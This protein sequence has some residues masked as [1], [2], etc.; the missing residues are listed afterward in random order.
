MGQSSTF[1]EI[2]K[3]DFNKIKN[4]ELVFKIQ[5]TESMETLQQN[6]FGVEFILKKLF[7]TKHH[8]IIEQIFNPKMFLGEK[9]DYENINFDEIDF[10]EI[11]DNSISYLEPDQIS[12]IDSLLNSISNS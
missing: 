12:K 3:T 1:Y 10:S 8:E 9:P 5:K 11:T 6:A 4:K 2:K 7:D